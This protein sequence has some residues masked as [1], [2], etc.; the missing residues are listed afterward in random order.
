MLFEKKEQG[1]FDVYSNE[2]VI[3]FKTE[4]KS[5]LF[6]ATTLEI[7]DEIRKLKTYNSKLNIEKILVESPRNLNRQEKN[8]LDLEF[9]NIF[10]SEVNVEY[11]KS[12]TYRLVVSFFRTP[13]CFVFYGS[14]KKSFQ[15]RKQ[16]RIKFLTDKKSKI[17]LN[18]GGKI[19]HLWFGPMAFNYAQSN[20]H[21]IRSRL[22]NLKIDKL[23]NVNGS[24]EISLDLEHDFIHGE[25]EIRLKNQE[26]GVFVS[27]TLSFNRNKY[28]S[29]LNRSELPKF[30]LLVPKYYQDSRINKLFFLAFPKNI[31]EPKVFNEK[32]SENKAY[33][34]DTGKS[35]NRIKLSGINELGKKVEADFEYVNYQEN[36]N[37]LNLSMGYFNSSRLED[38]F[39]VEY[40]IDLILQYQIQAQY[41]INRFIG[42]RLE[43][44]QD[45]YDTILTAPTGEEISGNR[46][47]LYAGMLFNLNLT[48]TDYTANEYY[49]TFGYRQKDKTYTSEKNTV[50]VLPVDFKGIELGVLA[51][52]KFSPSYNYNWLLEGTYSNSFLESSDRILRLKSSALVNLNL[53]SNWLKTDNYFNYY[54]RHD[55]WE[56]FSFSPS[57]EI[58]YDRR[59]ASNFQNTT[60]S[61]LD[62]VYSFGILYN[63]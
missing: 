32:L 22:L 51:N 16:I 23:Y 61:S 63:Y 9:Q 15:K 7:D 42:A 33:V 53:I 30:D 39:N 29:K 17:R 2:K 18:C 26:N 40:S 45:I 5:F 10:S 55:V 1:I 38:S 54:N 47:N 24:T 56:K 52:I 11:K 50:V 60:L 43:Y 4:Q 46:S 62:L 21:F 20:Y 28:L 8:I 36:S 31:L 41:F 25:K 14:S 48:P 44:S 27:K 6:D 57:L 19:K 13:S 58:I 49:F 35:V 59:K 34:V 12:G 37:F 3:T